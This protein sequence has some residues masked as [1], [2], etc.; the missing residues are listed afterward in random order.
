MRDTP[1]LYT[2]LAPA[3]HA[4]MVDLLEVVPAARTGRR[5]TQS[6]INVCNHGHLAA[7]GAVA[8]CL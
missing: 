6:Y 7:P 4:S 2:R 3:V 1:I 8:A 5:L